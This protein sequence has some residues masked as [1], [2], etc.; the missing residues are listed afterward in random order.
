MHRRQLILSGLA[1][2][3]GASSVGACATAPANPNYPIRSDNTA[4][5]AVAR[6]ERS[7]CG[8]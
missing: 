7:S 8:R 6:P 2:A 3:A 5:A 4:P 1:T